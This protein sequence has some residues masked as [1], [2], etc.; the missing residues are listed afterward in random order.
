M[1][2]YRLLCRVRDR[3]VGNVIGYQFWAA[4][5]GA[6]FVDDDALGHGEQ[7]AAHGAA[8]LFKN[9]RISPRTEQGLLDDVLRLASVAIRQP[10]DVAEQ[11]DGV[12]VVQR[13]QQVGLTRA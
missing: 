11:R 9:R 5:R 12:L 7:P 1:A 10:N 8:D 2:V 13:A 6:P 3:V 4:T